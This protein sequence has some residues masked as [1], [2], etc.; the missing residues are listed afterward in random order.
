MD[1]LNPK[2][3]DR[4]PPNLSALTHSNIAL[5]GGDRGPLLAVASRNSK[6]SSI[7]VSRVRETSLLLPNSGGME[8]LDE[9]EALVDEVISLIDDALALASTEDE[10]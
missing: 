3:G 9:M 6:H 2:W 10:R 5:Q 7:D 8:A 4:G 1:R